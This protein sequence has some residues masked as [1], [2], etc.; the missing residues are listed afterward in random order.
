MVGD[1]GVCEIDV[2]DRMDAPEL[3]DGRPPL[4]CGRAGTDCPDSGMGG[5]DISMLVASTLYCDFGL[6]FTAFDAL[7]KSL[8]PAGS[9]ETGRYW[10]VALEVCGLP[11]TSRDGRGPSFTFGLPVD[12]YEE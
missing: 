6:S 1:F 12:P 11:P 8:R 9:V 5:G 4:V 10:A 3:V 2:G 7:E